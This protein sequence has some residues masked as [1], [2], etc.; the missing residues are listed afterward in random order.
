LEDGV[1]LPIN[2]IL[3]NSLTELESLIQKIV[4]SNE[5]NILEANK[6]IKKLKE[7]I[8]GETDQEDKSRYLLKYL[9]LEDLKLNRKE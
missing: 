8:E 7:A 3:M 1:K 9:E 2:K 6:K 5:L 4:D